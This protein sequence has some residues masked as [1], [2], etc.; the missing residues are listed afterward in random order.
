MFCI[1]LCFIKYWSFFFFVSFL[2]VCLFVVVVVIVVVVLS[3]CCCFFFLF[4]KLDTV[5][6]RK[7]PSYLFNTVELL[8]FYWVNISSVYWDNT[9]YELVF[10]V[11]TFL[12]I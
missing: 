10:D 2:F 3:F 1:K 5:T 6:G 9:V 12:Y 11:D 7:T 8:D 4:F